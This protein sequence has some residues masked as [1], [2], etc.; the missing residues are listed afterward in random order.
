MEFPYMFPFCTIPEKTQK[1][2]T[3]NAS[4]A[5]NLGVQLITVIRSLF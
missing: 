3:P 1:V 5:T 2:A 4:N